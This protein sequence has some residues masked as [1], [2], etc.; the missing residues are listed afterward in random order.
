LKVPTNGF[1]KSYKCMCRVN[2][3]G[4]RSWNEIYSFVR[5]VENPRK[6]NRHDGKAE[7][8]VLVYIEGD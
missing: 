4:Q 1:W 6:L 8:T 2:Y 3:R 7:Q 5:A